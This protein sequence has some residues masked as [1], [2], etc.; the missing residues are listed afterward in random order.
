MQNVK[1]FLWK[2]NSFLWVRNDGWVQVVFHLEY[3]KA[4]Y[5]TFMKS[6][7][8]LKFEELTICSNHNIGGMECN[9]KFKILFLGVWCVVCDQV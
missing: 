2:G 9:Y 4:L 1:N 7:A 6:W 3:M 8:I 5:N